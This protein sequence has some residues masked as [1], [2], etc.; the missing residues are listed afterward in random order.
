MINAIFFI[1]ITMVAALHTTA[2]GQT[3]SNRYTATVDSFNAPSN[4]GVRRW[5]VVTDNVMN[6]HDAPSLDTPII[7]SVDDGTILDNLGCEKIRKRIW[8]GIRTIRTKKQ[9]YTL[10]EYLQPAVGPDGLVPMGSNSSSQLA[11]KSKFSLR[12]K[13]LCSQERGEGMGECSVGVALAGGGDAAVV[14]SFP[15]GFKRTLYFVNGEFISANTTMSGN[16]S[17]TDW[18]KDGDLHIIR[19]DDQR[20]KISDNLIFQTK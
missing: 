10:A 6:V 1:F 9:G 5:Q 17:D 7:H 20:Y 14:A 4:G 2:N 8:C 3:L 16:G 13:I 15:N 18:R 11:R 19:V 12:G